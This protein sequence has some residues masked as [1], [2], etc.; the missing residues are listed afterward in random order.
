MSGRAAFSCSRPAGITVCW[1]A[2]AGTLAAPAA[3]T[4]PG[5]ALTGEHCPHVDDLDAVLPHDF[6][7]EFAPYRRFV[8][9]CPVAHPPSSSAA[10]FVISVNVNNYYTSQPRTPMKESIPLPVLAAPDKIVAGRL[11]VPFPN[12]GP[13]SATLHFDAWRGDWPQS[14]RIT[15]ESDAVAPPAPILLIF[16]EKAHQFTRRGASK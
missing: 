2:L 4:P 1:L 3:T 8:Q 16:D 15:F 9:R 6:V 12:E 13:V 10:L 14:I 11:P 5:I 7:V